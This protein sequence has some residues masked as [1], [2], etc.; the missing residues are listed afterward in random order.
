MCHEG[1][2]IKLQQ[3]IICLFKKMKRQLE[4]YQDGEEKD[5][6]LRLLSSLSFLPYSIT[7]SLPQLLCLC[8]IA[9]VNMLQLG[10]Q[11]KSMSFTAACKALTLSCNGFTIRACGEQWMMNTEQQLESEA[12]GR[13]PVWGEQKKLGDRKFQMMIC[14]KKTK[15]RYKCSFCMCNVVVLK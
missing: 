6:L 10:S 14:G 7:P 15:V 12:S 1:T 8:S 13:R 2:A 4:S 3:K 5:S 9:I 11:A